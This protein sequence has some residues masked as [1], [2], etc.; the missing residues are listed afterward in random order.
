MKNNIRSIAV[1][2]NGFVHDFAAGIW[3]A[4]I[5][6]IALIHRMHQLRSPEVV[7]ILNRL[8][9]IFFW[10]SVVS[11][12]FIMATGAGRTFTYVD[13]WYGA[14]AERVRRRMLIIKHV[15]LLSAFG[16]GY[17]FVYPLVFH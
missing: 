11:M 3:L 17:L 9:H 4:A 13:N 6:S 2:L 14:D 7:A 12:V 1:I 10:T 16:A 5:A 8:E 15:V